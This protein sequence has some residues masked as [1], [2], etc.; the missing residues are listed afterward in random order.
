MLRLILRKIINNKWLVI[1]LIIGCTF[2]I[3]IGAAIPMYTSGLY[4]V[5]L[6][7]EFKQKQEAENT[8]PFRANYSVTFFGLESMA[9]KESYTYLNNNFYGNYVEEMPLDQIFDYNYMS[10]KFYVFIDELN[11]NKKLDALKEGI[12]LNIGQIAKKEDL[13]FGSL[14]K[15]DDMVEIIGGRLFDKN[16]NDGVIEVLVSQSCAARYR[17]SVGDTYYGY[18]RLTD[19][20]PVNTVEIVGIIKTVESATSFFNMSDR[21]LFMDYDQMIDKIESLD[22]SLQ[23]ASWFAAF[24]YTSLKMQDIEKIENLTHMLLQDEN[25][26]S[27]GLVSTSNNYLETLAKY[28]HDTQSMQKVFILLIIPIILM[29]AIYVVMISKLMMDREK[30]EIASLESRGAGRGQIFQIYLGQAL[31]LLVISL[32]A[33]LLLA[34]GICHLLGASNGFMEF[35]NRT[36]IDVHFNASAL[37]YALV[38]ALIYLVMILLP[39]YKASKFSIVEY[40]QSLSDISKKPFW[41]IIYLDFIVLAISTYFLYNY[42]TLMQYLENVE[43]LAIDF[44]LFIAVTFFITG[45]GLL[46]IRLFPYLIKLIFVIGKKRWKPALYTAFTHVARGGSYKQFIMLFLVL[47]IS[48]GIFNANTGRTLNENIKDNIKYEVGADAA[49]TPGYIEYYGDSGGI[50]LKSYTGRDIRRFGER[51]KQSPYIE[52]M[53]LVYSTTV[54]L[55]ATKE[56]ASFLGISPYEYGQVID[57]RDDLN[58][59]IDIKYFLNLLATYPQ[60]VLLSSN[61]GQVYD[62]KEGDYLTYTYQ[63]LGEQVMVQN[64]LVLGLVDYWPGIINKDFV[65]ITQDNYS[66]MKNFPMTGTL[67][68]DKKNNTSDTMLVNDINTY[69]NDN[70]YLPKSAFTDFILTNAKKSS[71]LNG[72][73]GILTLDFLISMIVC[74]VGF[75]IFWIISVRQRVLQFGIF[76]AMG[77]T[78]NELYRMIFYE[79]IMISL[80]SIVAGIIIGGLSSQL[81]VPLFERMSTIGEIHIPFS[82]YQDGIDYIRIY[83]VTGITLA[84]GLYILL[85]FI[86][87]LKID[88]ALK[89]GED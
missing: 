15:I 59:G 29:I 56:S 27:G 14:S 31:I 28:K 8:F 26:G 25:E 38:C 5:L 84:L 13:P 33:G 7:N 75:I 80:V 3:A 52:N 18:N 71:V 1:S 44:T 74:F 62:V 47:T 81:F 23:Q 53:A 51:I 73:N 24:D 9:S 36:K 55:T 54:S 4:N 48:I 82:T 41:Q 87:R 46:F 37:I 17:L 69:L 30:V 32:I 85:R 19:D 89:L 70:E 77:M 39:A 20:D 2:A 10:T 65:V 6:S 11:Q 79:Q 42:K 76:R 22:L 88:Q 66:T 35:V 57:L 63:S 58:K 40:K 12:K 61:L 34:R 68:I 64:V 49:I 45:L 72:I 43:S 78:S 21:V 86:S 83:S 16:R 67:L 50:E 60:G